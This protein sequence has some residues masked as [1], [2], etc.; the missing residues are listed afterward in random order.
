MKKLIDSF[1]GVILPT[2]MKPYSGLALRFI[3]KKI[4]DA[5]SCAIRE[6]K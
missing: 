1:F 4:S 2:T 5:R 6:G 3:G